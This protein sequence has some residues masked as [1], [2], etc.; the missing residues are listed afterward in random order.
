MNF[1]W[2][3]LDFLTTIACNISTITFIWYTFF[4][5]ILSSRL[6]CVELKPIIC[7][8]NTWEMKIIAAH[9]IQISMYFDDNW[10]THSFITEMISFAL[11]DHERMWSVLAQ[12]F[13]PHKIWNMIIEWDLDVVVGFH[14]NSSAWI[15]KR[16]S[17]SIE[18]M[19]FCMRQFERY[20]SVNVVDVKSSRSQFL[21]V[22]F[23]SF[24]LSYFLYA[25]IN[26][27]KLSLFTSIY[28]NLSSLVQAY[29]VNAH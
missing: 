17:V 9:S 27:E 23:L 5:T 24:F 11:K 8:R 29:R 22:F 3:L 13:V 25:F 21:L 14:D 10:H 26:H 18:A 20:A 16:F 28:I 1:M 12:L 15:L 4:F 7:Q 6:Y 19:L 2:S